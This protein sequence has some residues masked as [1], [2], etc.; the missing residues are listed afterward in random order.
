MP[1]ETEVG[2]GNGNPPSNP[3][4]GENVIPSGAG[5]LPGTHSP[6]RSR[7]H[8]TREEELAAH[9]RKIMRKRE[10]LAAIW[11]HSRFIPDWTYIARILRDQEHMYPKTRRSLS[12]LG[13]ALSN[14]WG[15]RH[16]YESERALT[17]WR[18]RT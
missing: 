14:T 1:C 13:L 18:F 9:V 7:P 4:G 10:V 6:S 2:S 17:E 12:D 8:L 16:Y 5:G 3:P 11:K 15:R